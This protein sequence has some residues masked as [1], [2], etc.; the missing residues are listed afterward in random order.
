MYNLNEIKT[1]IENIKDPDLGISLKELNGL[2]DINLDNN[3]LNISLL[4]PGPITYSKIDYEKI[5]ISVLKEAGINI[6]LNLKVEEKTENRIKERPG[7][8]KKVKYIIAVASG[9]GGVGKSTISANLATELAKQGAKV[10]ILDS[11]IYGPSQT[12]MFGVENEYME[13]ETDQHGH[14]KAFPVEKYGVKIASIGFVLNRRDAAGLRGPMLSNIF[15]SFYEQID[16]GELDYL[17]FDLPPGTGDI[18]LTFAQRLQPDGI[19]LVTTPQEISLADVRRSA[20]FFKDKLNIN[21]LGVVENM[22]YFVPPDMPEKKYYIFGQEG[23]KNIAIEL[24]LL[25]LGEVP[26]NILMRETSD[27]GKPIVLREDGG[28]QKEVLKD[29]VANMISELRRKKYNNIE[30]K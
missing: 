24:G 13:A 1:L 19:V 26:F 18:H 30:N 21:V 29:V 6:T 7:F 2:Q 3:N 4:L 11:D 23:G 27:S 20:V 15:N 16:W 28:T 17:I 25:L 22:S 8:L 12:I 5:I 9:K 14:T 10:G